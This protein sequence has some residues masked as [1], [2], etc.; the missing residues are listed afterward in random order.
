M[1]GATERAVE[2]AICKKPHARDEFAPLTTVVAESVKALD[3]LTVLSFRNRPSDQIAEYVH[4]RKR[5]FIV[6]LPSR[7]SISP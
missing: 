6:A 1:T 4:Y 5:R 7:Y 3:G 2:A